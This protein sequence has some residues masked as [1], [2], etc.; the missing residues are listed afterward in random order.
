MRPPKANFEFKRVVITKSIGQSGVV[1]KRV[2]LIRGSFITLLSS[3]TIL[4]CAQLRL[5][6]YVGMAKGSLASMVWSIALAIFGISDLHLSFSTGKPMDIF[7]SHWKNHAQKMAESWDSM[8]GPEDIVLCPGD[9]SWAMRLDE[10]QPD[11]QWIGDRPGKKI[12]GRGNHDYWW[13]GIKKVRAALPESC[14]A[15]QND[16][17]ALDDAVIA[18]SRLWSG[19]GA[20]D[21]GPDDQKIYERELSRLELSLKNAQQIS[22]GKPIIASVH[23]PPSGLM[24]DLHISYLYFMSNVEPS[25]LSV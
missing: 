22:E 12:L 21:Y 17:V 10:A 8:V 24:V 14:I 6:I 2:G 18:G 20:L 4:V 1:G 11:L 3:I 16:A 25:A 19:P 7:G 9:L 5:L 23:Y 15:L 13:N